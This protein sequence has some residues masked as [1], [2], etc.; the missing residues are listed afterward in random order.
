MRRKKAA[1]SRVSNIA[2]RGRTSPVCCAVWLTRT[3]PCRGAAVPTMESPWFRLAT[4]SWASE[5][6]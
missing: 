5:R 4:K 6:D 3:A 2:S 1:G